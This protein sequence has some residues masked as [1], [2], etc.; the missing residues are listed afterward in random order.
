MSAFHKTPAHS[1]VALITGATGFLGGAIAAELLERE[2]DVRPLF[3]VR[4]S[5][6]RSGLQALRKSILRFEPSPSALLRLT[7]DSVFCGDLETFPSLAADPR[8]AAITH[9][10]NC[11]ALVS[12]AWK[13]EVWRTNVEHTSAFADCIARLPALRRVLHVSTAMVS[14]GTTDQLVCEDD[15]PGTARQFTLYTKSKAEIERR[16]PAALNGALVI[17]RPSIIVGHTRIGCK[18]SPSIFWLFRM[19]HAARRLP[20]SPSRRID[21]VPVD[22]CARALVHL[23][24]KTDL[25]HERYHVSAGHAASCSFTEIDA[26]YSRAR[27][28]TGVGALQEFDV[29][30]LREIETQFDDWFGACDSKSAASAIKVY[31]AFARLNVTFDNARLLAEG[32]AAPPRFVDYLG[33]CVRTGE[34]QTIADQ[35]VRESRLSTSSREVS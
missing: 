4:A 26:A 35:M 11:A 22:Y 28:E 12:F 33:T 25:A 14:G 16:L 3:L 19:M 7:E 8:A 13:R 31:R 6:S 32:V 29:A 18:P 2:L 1:A 30:T 27:D 9:V 5:D 15:F 10:L 34:N 24:F 21:V 23:L 20:F 17:A